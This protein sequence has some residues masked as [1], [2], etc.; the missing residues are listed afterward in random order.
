[1]TML[2]VDYFGL[3]PVRDPV[4]ILIIGD[5]PV[6]TQSMIS[7]G[8]D[9]TY[10][11]YT[12]TRSLKERCF[13]LL[14][15][16]AKAGIPYQGLAAATRRGYLRQNP[17]IIDSL[18]RGFAETSAFIQKPANREIVIRSL[19]KNLRLKNPQDAEAGYSALPW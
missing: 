10:L 2:V 12:H 1:M 5:S 8:I 18:M 3:G 14:L 17:Q 19:A 13:P 15:D 16:M 6:L 11:N 9:A 7:G 4:T